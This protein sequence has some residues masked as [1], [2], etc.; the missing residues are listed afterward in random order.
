MAVTLIAIPEVVAILELVGI[1]KADVERVRAKL[2]TLVKH[3]PQHGDTDSVTVS[4]GYGRNSERG[5][6]E[7][8]LNDQRSQMEP[9]KAREIGLMLI[10]S[11][12]AAISDQCVIELLKRVGITSDDARGRILIDLREI[13]QGTRGIAWPT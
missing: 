10:E 12:E 3:K 11:A 4:S 5:F 13:R 2:D 8:T 6:V 9:A 1:K 7:L